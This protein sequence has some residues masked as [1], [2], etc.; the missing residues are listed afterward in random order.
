M[1]MHSILYH[2]DFCL[3]PPLHS[4][5]SV[6]RMHPLRLSILLNVLF[7]ISLQAQML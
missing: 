1:I 7:R 6:P 4:L 5:S 3:T 2:G